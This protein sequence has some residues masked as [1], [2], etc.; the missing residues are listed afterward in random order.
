MN[1]I[2]IIIPTYNRQDLLKECIYYLS[3]C[4]SLN[5]FF[6]ITSEEPNE[7]CSKIIDKIYFIEVVRN[8]N[9]NKLGCN[10]NLDKCINYGL[11][12]EKFIILED[13]VLPSID[14]LEYFL[15]AFNESKNMNEIFFINAYHKDGN[16]HD[17]EKVCRTNNFMAWGWGCYSSKYV[18]LKSMGFKIEYDKNYNHTTNLPDAWDGQL[19]EFIL[20]CN[21]VK[22]LKPLLSR[23]QNVGSIGTWTTDP[24]WHKNNVF[25]NQWMSGLD[26]SSINYKII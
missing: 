8:K 6:V 10:A 19:N 26:Y 23:V 16:L 14:F 21:N 13:D 18:E 22:I 12:Y 17:Y 5:N 25:C 15:W 1:K 20:N 24:D 7:E 4:N 9:I 2:P 3:K 11:Q